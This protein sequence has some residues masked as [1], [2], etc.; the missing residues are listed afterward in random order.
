[1][2]PKVIHYCWFGHQPLPPLAEKCIRS[3][4]KHMPDYEIKRWDESCFDVNRIAYT[5]EAYRVGKYAFVS[6]YA[7]LWILYHYGGVYFDTDVEVLK[8]FEPILAQGA[9]MGCQN[10]GTDSPD[11]MDI[12]VNTGLGIAAQSGLAVYRDL[13]QLYSGLSFIHP[14][15]SYNLKTVVEYTT[16]ILT[17]NYGLQ[18]LKGIQK[19]GEI[20][21]YPTEYFNPKE[22]Y[23]GNMNI[24]N[25][26]Y[27]IH[28]YSMSWM[29]KKAVA[30]FYAKRWLAK[31]LGDHNAQALLIFFFKLRKGNL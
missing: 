28:H 11:R 25:N 5:S 15:G 18:N 29:G 9:F 19:L 27:S 12:D 24:T 31:I 23:T 7:R 1:M 17:E 6:D 20:T 10:D 2:I 3:W 4:R 8:S 21:I 13:L 14:D 16:K 30:S 22:Y 26:T